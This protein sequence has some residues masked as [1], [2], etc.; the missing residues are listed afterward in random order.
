MFITLLKRDDFC[1]YAGWQAGRHIE[2][3]FLT[4]SNA[5]M[6]LKMI[7]HTVKGQKIVWNTIILSCLYLSLDIVDDIDNPVYFYGYG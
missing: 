6:A 2:T 5:L 7:S 1:L 3:N 4:G